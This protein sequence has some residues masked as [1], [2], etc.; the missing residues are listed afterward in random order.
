M[1]VHRNSCIAWGQSWLATATRMWDT[2]IFAIQGAAPSMLLGQ[3]TKGR[4]YPSHNAN[5]LTRQGW[6]VSGFTKETEGTV[7]RAR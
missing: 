1:W 4:I 3:T 5:V 2:S 6:F 7:Q